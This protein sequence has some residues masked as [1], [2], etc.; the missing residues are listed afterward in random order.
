MYAVAL[1][2]LFFLQDPYRTGLAHY[3]ERQYAKAAEDFAQVVKT[4][5]PI[6]QHTANL[7]FCLVKVC[8]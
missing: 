6:A 8:T 1:A 2:W 3:K 4:N 7:P 5:R